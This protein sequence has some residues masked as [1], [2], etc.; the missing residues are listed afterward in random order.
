[1]A[2]STFH[3]KARAR[4]ERLERSDCARCGKRKAKLWFDRSG[5]VGHGLEEPWCEVCVLEVQIAWAEK[6]AAA[7]PGLRTQLA[8]LRIGLCDHS[9]DA[10]GEEGVGRALQ[11]CSKCYG[12]RFLDAPDVVFDSARLE[13]MGA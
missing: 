5:I 1:M 3:D 13:G 2:E 11:V 8:E 4:Q 12:A 6:S 10:V 7:L 9:W